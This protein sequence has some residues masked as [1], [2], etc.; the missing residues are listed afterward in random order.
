[1]AQDPATIFSHLC[2]LPNQESNMSN[3]YYFIH[4]NGTKIGE[5]LERDNWLIGTMDSEGSN[6]G[7]HYFVHIKEG[8]PYE[9]GDDMASD[10]DSYVRIK[11][12]TTPP[13]DDTPCIMQLAENGIVFY[14]VNYFIVTG[15]QEWMVKVD[16]NKASFRC[17]W[18][19]GQYLGVKD[20]KLSSEEEEVWWTIEEA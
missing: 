18:L 1:M 4:P 7:K 11:T 17:A 16:G 3:G 5:P 6:P 19:E 13:E 20:G 15:K 2:F 8:T 9:F 12:G 10:Q 14:Q